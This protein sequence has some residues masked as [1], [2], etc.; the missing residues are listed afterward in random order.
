MGWLFDHTRPGHRHL[1][2][3]V[4]ADGTVLAETTASNRRHDLEAEGIGDGNYGFALTVSALSDRQCDVSVREAQSGYELGSVTLPKSTQPSIE[5]QIVE[6]LMD[7]DFYLSIYQDVS[8]M[9]M[10]PVRHFVNHGF[11]EGRNPSPVF[12]TK[13]YVVEHSLEGTG[14][15]PLVH[16]GLEVIRRAKSTDFSLLEGKGTEASHT[17]PPDSKDR[18]AR[19]EYQIV[20]AQL[21]REFYLSTYPDLKLA[22]VDPVR[23]YIEHGSREGRN[24]S[25]TFGTDYYKRQH[26]L[27]DS[28]INPLVHRGLE[29]IRRPQIQETVPTVRDTLEDLRSAAYRLLERKSAFGSG[30]QLFKYAPFDTDKPVVLLVIFAHEPVL[31][32]LQRSICREYIA[33]G[34]NLVVI[35]NQVT[36]IRP[37]DAGIPAG[38]KAVICR[39]NAGFDFAAWREAYKLLGPF[40]EFPRVVM[41]NDSVIPTSNGLRAVIDAHVGSE[42]DWLFSTRNYEIE[43][44]GQSFFMSYRPSTSDKHVSRLLD[45]PLLKTKQEVI[46]KVEIPLAERIAKLGLAVD[47]LVDRDVYHPDRAD[48]NPTLHSARELVDNG[49]LLVKAEYLT[50]EMGKLQSWLEDVFDYRRLSE[51]QRHLAGRYGARCPKDRVGLFIPAG[52]P[53]PKRHRVLLVGHNA[54]V[55]GAQRLLLALARSLTRVFHYEVMILLEEGGNNLSQFQDIAPT[56][57][58]DGD[59]SVLKEVLDICRDCGV[60][61]AILNTVVPLQRLGKIYAAGLQTMCLVHEM[62]PAIRTLGLEQ[63]VIEGLSAL[64]H[65]VYPSETVRQSIETSLGCRSAKASIRSQGHF[66]ITRSN[67]PCEETAGVLPEAVAQRKQNGEKLV[68]CV[69]TVEKRKGFDRFHEVAKAYRKAYPKDR[70]SFVWVG[71]P[72][73]ECDVLELYESAL[74]DPD[75]LCLPNMDEAQLLEIYKASAVYF[76]ASRHDAMPYAVIDALYT[77]LPLVGYDNTG[78]CDALIDRYGIRLPEDAEHALCLSALHK[79]LGKREAPASAEA[80]QRHVAETMDFDDYAAGLMSYF[81]D[82]NPKVFVAVPNY[83]HE[84][85]LPARLTSILEQDYKYFDLL[86][87]DDKSGDGSIAVMDRFKALYTPFAKTAYNRKNSG[88]SYKQWQKAMAAADAELLWIAESDDA[89]ARSFLSHMIEPF[90]DPDVVMGYSQTNFMDETGKLFG[91]IQ[92]DFSWIHPYIWNQSYKVPGVREIRRCLSRANTIINVSS[93]LFRRSA[94]PSMDSVLKYRFAGDWELYIRMCEKG[95]VFFQRM[96]QNYFRRSSHAQTSKVAYSDLFYRE[97]NMI[98]RT[99]SEVAGREA[100]EQTAET[101]RN[102]WSQKK[103]EDEQLSTYLSL[104]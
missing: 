74:D 47:Y 58:L 102:H 31:T 23:H 3:A 85:F 45:H 18:N 52:T 53:A 34:A 16:R 73:P 69:G 20:E 36:R 87:M 44:H 8:S 77:G 1:V 48:L 83:R 22:G 59:E 75:I 6:A 9:S 97:H 24:P 95:S 65:V 76:F 29:L 92:D 50:D 27:E 33:T 80:R 72:Q 37:E 5:Y 91:A 99:I 38:A 43:P 15:N 55:G 104:N 10:D 35:L 103:V 30:S 32:D 28:G 93:A 62:A 89:C 11:K 49:C 56:F 57:V 82:Y 12:D 78:G 51:I 61:K 19:L 54:K 88:N 60:D 40:A 79:F 101:I 41:T 2:Q 21:D 68:L 94:L 90:E 84:T 26:K 17:L 63:A 25:A 100:A 86:L 7:S 14:I 66:R 98:M 81:G 64:D 46:D 67:F 13:G 42:S 4:A 96:A 70:V 39:E 71:S